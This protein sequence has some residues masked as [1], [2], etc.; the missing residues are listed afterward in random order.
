MQ[1]LRV[2]MAVMGVLL[3]LTGCGVLLLP[4]SGMPSQW[5]TGIIVVALGFILLI[6]TAQEAAQAK[7][8]L[9]RLAALIPFAK[10]TNS[11]L[12]EKPTMSPNGTSDGRL[13][14]FTSVFCNVSILRWKPGKDQVAPFERRKIH[15]LG[16]IHE[17]DIFDEALVVTDRTHRPSSRPTFGLRSSSSGLIAIQSIFPESLAIDTK[18]YHRSGGKGLVAD[19][20]L[21]N[22]G[23]YLCISRRY[24][25]FQGEEQDF[26]ITQTACRMD[27][28]VLEVNFESVLG[29]CAFEGLPKAF[30][31]TRRSQEQSA[32]PI[33]PG[34]YGRSW[35]ATL[36]AVEEES[37]LIRWRL[38]EGFPGG[39][40]YVFGYGSL[41]HPTSIGKN[42]SHFQTSPL[43]LIPARLSGFTRSWSA[44]IPNHSSAQLAGG[45][46]PEHL[47]FMNLEED[48]TGTAL[49]VLIP[50]ARDDLYAL[51]RRESHYV[52]LDVS[53]SVKPIERTGEMIPPDVRIFA[54]ICLPPM[55]R[56]KT[57]SERCAIR[58]DY[59]ELV[60]QAG[61]LIDRQ[62]G[63]SSTVES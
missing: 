49:G 25:A 40:V 10:S 50:V 59:R 42:L 39:S 56:E 43:E 54:Y 55:S 21:G 16:K 20:P 11:H 31:E 34:C 8:L 2:V 15:Y 7:I 44:I 1:P 27:T 29:S 5:Q 14:H 53:D 26:K 18:Y 13:P 60:R 33:E 57:S 30:R 51:D 45:K 23:H 19:I 32:V 46:V 28:V 48:A 62:L 4:L 47:V 9:Q 22:A 52:R 36:N 17:V 12:Q 38:C 24:N 63:P 61:C 6:L 41:M 37:L 58:K 35:K 3:L